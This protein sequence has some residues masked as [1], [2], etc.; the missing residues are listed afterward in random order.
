MTEDEIDEA[1][2]NVEKN[3]DSQIE[4]IE[5]KTN[6]SEIVENASEETEAVEPSEKTADV[7]T[8]DVEIANAETSAEETSNSE[9]SDLEETG[10]EVD[11]QINQTSD[12]GETAVHVD[13]DNKTDDESI[14]ETQPVETPEEKDSVESSNEETPDVDAELPAEV[15]NEED[16]GE[17]STV[18][19]QIEDNEPPVEILEEDNTGEDSA[20]ENT[21]VNTEPSSE[22]IEEVNADEDSNVDGQEENPEP[23]AD[24]PVED[25]AEDISNEESQDMNPEAPSDVSDEPSTESEAVLESEGDGG[26][27]NEQKTEVEPE[28]ISK[29]KENYYDA[30]FSVENNILENIA[31]ESHIEKTEEPSNS[32]NESTNEVEVPD[33]KTSEEDSVVTEPNEE[34]V[35]T[36]DDETN[37]TEVEKPITENPIED[38]QAVQDENIEVPEQDD[39]EITP[40]EVEN[41]LV[42]NDA[43]ENIVADPNVSPEPNVEDNA[44]VEPDIGDTA[45][46]DLSPT[47]VSP[48][49]EA[50]VEAAVEEVT[51]ETNAIESSGAAADVENDIIDNVFRILIVDDE[52]E[53]SSALRRALLYAKEFKSEIQTVESGEKALTELEKD[54]Y[55]LI[56]TDYRMPG[57]TGTEFL[58][59]VRNKY[60]DTIRIIITGYSDIEIIKEAVNKAEIHH[61]IEKPWVNDGVRKVVHEALQRKSV[62]DSSKKRLS[63]EKIMSWLMDVYNDIK[64]MGIDLS[65]IDQNIQ[66][67]QEALD[68]NNLESALT[69]INHSVNILKKYAELS[70]PHINVSVMNE[71]QLPA[72]KWSK[73]NLV[74]FNK[75]NS[76]A[77]DIQ[78][79]V[80]S[81]FKVKDIEVIPEIKVNETKAIILEVLPNENGTFPLELDINCKKPF[82]N[83]GYKFDEIFWFRIGDVV[84]TTKL[85]RKFGYHKGYIKMELG[86]INDDLRDIREVN[87]EL[88]YENDKLTLSDI[89]PHHN[90]WDNKFQIGNIKSHQGSNVE[91]YFDPLICS[92]T[93]IGGKVSFIDWNGYEKNITLAPQTIRILCP[94]LFTG[95]KI[96]LS[97]LKELLKNELKYNGNKVINI[98]V[99]IDIEALLK[100]CKELVF[101]YDVKL[102]EELVNEVP[103]R[104]ETW[105][106]GTTKDKKNKFAI[107]VRIDEDT[108]SL[109]LYVASAN[110]AAIAGLLA[111][112]VPK[113]SKTLEDRGITQE[114]LKQMENITIK[115]NLI[116]SKRFLF[117]E[118]LD[119]LGKRLEIDF[120]QEIREKSK[121]I[122]ERFD[123]IHKKELINIARGRHDNAQLK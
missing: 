72:N 89:K 3:D 119:K 58:Q 86:I 84:G 30:K 22:D 18:E 99:G 49:E 69:Y 120:A 59:R 77:K 4:E 20:G 24:V 109:E 57:M 92:K 60:P 37:I 122:R 42:E 79:T 95:D 112:F 68:A 39:V 15:S 54:E 81:E 23:S 47:S 11:E 38:N 41:K 63:K 103:Q 117:Y 5:N 6:E 105:F 51:A 94:E 78:I 76:N 108:N 113:L 88:N 83:S 66:V 21:E 73:L 100:I 74:V 82:D 98:P 123:N 33:E 14:T 96:G 114:P 67:A 52:N 80:N 32:E 121:D 25:S 10:G 56:L 8:S 62:R 35:A 50:L 61:Y 64:S 90:M 13:A 43:A 70:Y 9:N 93:I 46:E 26:I 31:A 45:T 48:S 2:V 115:N 28:N 106:Y 102:I 1:N 40:P 17:N 116:S 104:I 16:G 111:D 118:R 65:F 19:S 44:M 110:N 36:S 29:V 107:K 7:E 91:I 27:E 101:S 85:K 75:G 55:D 53:V 97:E 12:D 71:L 34:T 87:L